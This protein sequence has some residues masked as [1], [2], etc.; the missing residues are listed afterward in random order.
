MSTI[1]GS[2]RL[3]GIVGDP[4][5]AVRSPQWFNAAFAAAGRN[6]V[7]VPLHVEA[8]GLAALWRGLHQ[9]RN[10]DGLVI[11]MP[12]KAAAAAL[13]DERD[14]AASRVGAINAA[15]RRPDGAW[16]GAMFD[17]TGFVE[18]LRRA[19]HDVA[20]WRV[21][22]WGLGGAGTAVALALA[23]AGAA[24][25][26]LCDARPDRIAAVRALL[27]EIPGLVVDGDGG[28]DADLMVNATPLGM[29]ADDPLPFD[30]AR[31]TRRAVVA[32]LVST[33]EM[34]PLLHR[35]AQHGHAIH[36][37]RHLHECQA[38]LAARFFRLPG[39]FAAPRWESGPHHR[40]GTPAPP[41]GPA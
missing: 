27:R 30:P 36:T 7:L 13:V 40:P 5:S 16:E 25:L 22:L 35:A 38:A 33:P 3:F 17:G 39:T 6:A 8:A 28:F 19:G 34:T 26:S 23:E 29:A 24:S 15:R 2:T 9:V 37:G 1:D 14:A 20:G 31:L 11:T 32:D 4:V 21:R 10:L 18:G 12:H 41:P